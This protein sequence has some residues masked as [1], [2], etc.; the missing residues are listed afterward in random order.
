MAGRLW[1]L[2]LSGCH[3]WRA[4]GQH[5]VPQ[6][7]RLPKAGRTRQPW[8]LPVPQ[9]VS[10]QAGWLKQE[11][12]L[13]CP[14]VPHPCWAANRRCR[15]GLVLCFATDKQGSPS[16]RCGAGLVPS[17]ATAYQQTSRQLK[18][19]QT[20]CHS[21]SQS[22]GHPSSPGR[23]Q[24]QQGMYWALQAVQD[25]SPCAASWLRC[26]TCRQQRPAR[27]SL[28]PAPVGSQPPRRT[29]HQCEPS[30]AGS[31]HTASSAGSMVTGSGRPLEMTQWAADG[32]GSGPSLLHAAD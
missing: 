8:C 24:D 1:A 28:R 15:A 26:P 22:L 16:T 11:V 2:H 25:D 12:Q 32:T 20:G 21:A 29:S 14:S 31:H 13:W 30:P 7:S 5:H 18:Q 4:A 23:E 27:S 17:T 10:R 9:L 3:P 19:E 6:P